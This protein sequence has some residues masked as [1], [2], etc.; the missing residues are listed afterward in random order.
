MQR[1]TYNVDEMT[2]EIL[3]EK[4][5]EAGLS[6]SAALRVLARKLRNGSI[7]LI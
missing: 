2:D 3:K 4:A 1:R 5:R 6:V 7:R